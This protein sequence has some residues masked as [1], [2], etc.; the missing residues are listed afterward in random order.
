MKRVLLKILFVA[1]VITGSGSNLSNPDEPIPAYLEVKG[2]SVS[3]NYTTQGTASS[4]VKDVWVY[5]GGSYLG[6]FEL[7]A[8]IPIL[9]EGKHKISLG[10]GIKANGISSTSEFYNLYKFHDIEVDLIPGKIAVVDTFT[11]SY[12]PALQY[13][14]FEDFEQ[15]TSGGGISL[16]TTGISLA[17]IFT[18]SVEVF[19]GKRSLRMLVDTAR[20]FLECRT[21]NSGYTLPKGRDVYLE[22]DYK[23]SDPFIMG[24]IGVT[25]NG[26]RLIPIIR[27]NPK[28]DW[29]K[30]YV[31]L[32]PYVN[33]NFDA[34]LF[35]VYFRLALNAGKTESVVY[36][37]NLKLISN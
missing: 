17:E 9:L 18:D 37:D 23:C 21:I 3:S 1:V 4:N 26:E 15:D 10:A 8:R 16:D 22:M 28:S 7:P 36:L 6:T 32:G 25:I 20:N 12:F 29:N 31:R 14:W 2:I 5:V 24:L 13:T 19:E 27:L 35:K 30:I 11:V 33:F 34:Y